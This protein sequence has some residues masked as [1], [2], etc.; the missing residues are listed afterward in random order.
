MIWLWL[1]IASSTGLFLL[2]E[3]IQKKQIAL[4]PSIVVNYIVCSISGNI[5]LNDKHIFSS[6]ITNYP[7]WYY[8]AAMG[9]LFIVTFFL[10]G[11]ATASEGA[12]KSSVASKMSVVVPVL[13]S[14]LVMKQIGSWMQGVGIF[15]GL[16]SVFFITKKQGVKLLDS[17]PALLL[18][19]F[20]G[21]GMVD[22]GLNLLA[23]KFG[24]I[25]QSET[26]ISTFIFSCAGAI[27]ILLLVYN[28]LNQL[29]W[30]SAS[31]GVVL[32]LVNFCSLLCVFKALEA[33]K[34][35]T[36]NYWMLNN[37]GVVVSSTL[38]SVLLF[39]RKLDRNN[40]IGLAIA[41]LA[42]ISLNIK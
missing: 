9:G 16:V 1:S 36:A 10:M 40:Y 34:N 3:F 8:L 27:G 41:I 33:F 20:M 13:V 19:V 22:A 25:N 14:I 11:Y 37:I 26:F 6:E 17:K 5:L 21:S 18:A 29:N 12:S 32:G 35:N 7:E 39:Q 31:I 15:L 2:F 38:L 30:Q 28:K 42:I 24:I 23:Y 4:F